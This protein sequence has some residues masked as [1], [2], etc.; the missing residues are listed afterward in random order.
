MSYLQKEN[1]N[2]DMVHENEDIEC[3]I[4]NEDRNIKEDKFTVNTARIPPLAPSREAAA[5]TGAKVITLLNITV[6]AVNDA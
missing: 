5:K 3:G 1:E 6:P 2:E 4:E